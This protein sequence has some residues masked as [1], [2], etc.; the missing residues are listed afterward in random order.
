M[1]RR[2]ELSTA[3]LT[4]VCGTSSEDEGATLLDNLQS[5]LRAPDSAL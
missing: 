4:E 1:P 3:L 2:L 5:L